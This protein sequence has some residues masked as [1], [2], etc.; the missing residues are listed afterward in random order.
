MKLL[1]V[2]AL[3]F[4]SCVTSLEETGRPQVPHYVNSVHNEKF[5]LIDEA[6]TKI[7]S[8]P[9]FIFTKTNC[10]N[11]DEVFKLFNGLNV[12]FGSYEILG[13][14]EEEK[15]S[16]ALQSLTGLGVIP[17]VFVQSQPVGSLR[18]VQQEIHS[19]FLMERLRSA[20]AL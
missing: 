12:K 4:F 15:W 19:G 13:E 9:V 7:A 14:E 16:E 2:F 18:E 11:C 3:F 17:A 6:Y 10:P 5:D 8:Q 20:G 1:L